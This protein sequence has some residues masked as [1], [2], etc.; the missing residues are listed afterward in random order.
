MEEL[1][2]RVKSLREDR[3]WTQTELGRRSNVPQSAI[4]YIESGIRN[5][6]ADTLR[7]LAAAL[8]V[9]VAA[10]LDETTAKASGE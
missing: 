2:I 6:R 3:G 10:L 5:P 1:A 7:K 9:T 4:H 8:G